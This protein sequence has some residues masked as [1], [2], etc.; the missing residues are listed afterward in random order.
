MLR[1]VYNHP[2]CVAAGL[3]IVVA[4]TRAEIAVEW[5]A[6]YGF[7]APRPD[8]GRDVAVDAAGNVFVAGESAVAVQEHDYVTIKYDSAGRQQWLR[9]YN[10][11]GDFNDEAR[12]IGVDTEG[13]AYV[14]GISWGGGD[15]GTGPKYDIV[16]IKYDTN[17]N[18][19][20]LH[21]FNSVFNDDDIIQDM[22]VLPDG[23]VYIVGYS[24][25]T[26]NQMPDADYVILKIDAAGSLLWHRFYDGTENTITWLASALAADA[27]G[28]S[29][30]ASVE[31]IT[32]NGDQSIYGAIHY[33]P[34][35]NIVW[36]NEWR[37]P[38]VPLGF[39]DF[40]I[41]FDATLDTQGNF[42]VAGRA[43]DGTTSDSPADAYLVKFDA[44]GQIAWSA[45]NRTLRTDQFDRVTTDAQGNVFA[46][47]TFN[48][49]ENFTLHAEH[50]TA[51]YDADGN[52]L[53]EHRFGGDVPNFDGEGFVALN[54]RGELIA[55]T[56]N[57]MDAT[58]ED[59]R[60]FVYDRADGTIL[61]TTAFDHGC[62]DW[63]T[64]MT[65]DAQD[66]IILTGHSRPDG[67][68][69]ELTVVKISAGG[70]TPGDLDGDGVVGIT[71]FLALL[72][73]W[74]PCAGACPADLDGDDAVGILDLLILLA[75][76]G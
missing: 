50:L 46:A 33:D 23:T 36:E 26:A 13:N 53:W 24:R 32:A 35:G 10:G 70:A 29:V 71:D 48:I 37:P 41:V 17:G 54:S 42:L 15:F 30:A 66:N 51:A 1:N 4:T 9:H 67:T 45:I 28:V 20:W 40:N 6:L 63:I 59:M 8:A 27:T 11:D 73:A 39:P 34:D 62:C 72:A 43:D 18:Q 68:N 60:V 75:N 3:L 12:N 16:T 49:E 74:G 38:M 58:G 31:V 5:S 19:L 22:T 61:D 7:E 25:S 52:F 21:R 44:T 2:G 55:A 64:G 57:I 65:L 76:W 47:G 14:S 69:R 56:R